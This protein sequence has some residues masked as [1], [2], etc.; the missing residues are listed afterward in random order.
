MANMKLIFKIFDVFFMSIWGLTVVDLIKVTS[1]TEILLNIDTKIKT[2]MALVG[3]IYFLI[4][5]PHKLKTQKQDRI[6]KEEQIKKIKRENELD[7]KD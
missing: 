1:Q 7:K 4:Q 6:L 2:I 5:I 3:L